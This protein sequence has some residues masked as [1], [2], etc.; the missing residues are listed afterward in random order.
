MNYE[1]N[2]KHLLTRKNY[3]QYFKVFYPPIKSYLLINYKSH[4]PLI[5]LLI[6]KVNLLA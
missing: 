4:L 2:L 1:H 5:N 3:E 6:I